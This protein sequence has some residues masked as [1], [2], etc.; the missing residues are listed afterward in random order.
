V[1]RGSTL[2]LTARVTNAGPSSA[3]QLRFSE[4]LPAGVALD[5]VA[6]SQGSCSGS[7][8]ITC[9][10]GTLAANAS[11]TVTVT[12]RVTKK[13]SGNLT[14]TASVAAAET[15]PATANNVASAVT[16]LQSPKGGK[17]L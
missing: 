8:T 3:K 11:A 2:V 6:P 4:T 14:T 17:A 16:R 7:G 9:A 13:G 1:Q 15:D 12:V 5:S 10:L